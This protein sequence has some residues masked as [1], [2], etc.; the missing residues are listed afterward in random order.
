MNCDFC[1]SKM[2]L[3]I[4]IHKDNKVSHICEPCFDNLLDGLEVDEEEADM[5]SH[6][7]C[8]A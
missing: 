1:S 4:E 5:Y 6:G 8:N 2:E 7:D 3:F